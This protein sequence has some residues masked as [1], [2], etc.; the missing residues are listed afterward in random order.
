MSVNNTPIG[1]KPAMTLIH[2]VGMNSNYWNN[3]ADELA[4][5]FSITVVNLPG[6]GESPLTANPSPTLADYTDDVVKSLHQPAIVVGH[7]LG[8]LVTL[9][10]A[11]RY[12][13]KTIGIGVLNGVYRRSETASNAIQIRLAELTTT[14]R[15]DPTSTL[16]RWFGPTPSGIN[17]IAADN[18][19]KWL[20]EIDPAGYAQAYKAFANADAPTDTQL[21]EINCPA[22]FM[23]GADEPNSTPAMSIAMSKLV[24]FSRCVIVPNA[25]H[26]MPLTH[27]LETASALIDFFSPV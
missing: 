27:G 5:H 7:S 18:C 9:D 15:S 14:T 13:D 1:D 2:G 16:N 24:P 17:A 6:H 26:M 4:R 23:T 19:R 11:V 3:I 10:L 12:P 20:N 22:L 25:K 8:A 21:S